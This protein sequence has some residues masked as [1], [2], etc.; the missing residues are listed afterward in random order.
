MIDYLFEDRPEEEEI[1]IPLARAYGVEL[2]SRLL[3]GTTNKFL[4]TADGAAQDGCFLNPTD[5]MRD[6]MKTMPWSTDVMEGL[7]AN[8]KNFFD[9]NSQNAEL[10][11]AG[12][13]SCF[14][15]N[16]IVEFLKDLVCTCLYK[17]TH[18]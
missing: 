2:Q 4:G 13:C 8:C 11:S 12:A 16:K 6:Q 9:S 17:C 5:E 3:N 18:T 10:L 14:V 7:Y 1:L 15:V